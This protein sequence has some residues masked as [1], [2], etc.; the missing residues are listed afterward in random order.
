MSGKH[1]AEYYRR[2]RQT[3][4]NYHR[5]SMLSNAKQRSKRCG[6]PFSITAAD[7]VIPERCPALGIQLAH[8]KGAR[9]S[10]NSPTVDRIIPSK[11]YV[12]G[13]IIVVSL[14]ANR[15]KNNASL[16]ELE[17]I[18]SFYRKLIK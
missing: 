10:E 2:W 7:I 9:Q 16:E 13:N 11:G 17:A 5:N 15:I 18:T 4:P 14:K 1:S 12:P 3:A 6:V 8:Q